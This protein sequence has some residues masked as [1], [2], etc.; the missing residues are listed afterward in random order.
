MFGVRSLTHIIFDFDSLLYTV[1]WKYNVLV[2]PFGGEYRERFGDY[3]MTKAP[4][5][6]L[7]DTR[8]DTIYHF[9]C[10]TGDGTR[11][12]NRGR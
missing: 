7:R 2:K 10:F 12:Y 1:A 8:H 9:R 11:L 5:K 4:S 3:V 6:A